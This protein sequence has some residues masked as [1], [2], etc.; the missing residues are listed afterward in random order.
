MKVWILRLRSFLDRLKISGV[1]YPKNLNRLFVSVIE[2]V[3]WKICNNPSFKK[4]Y[5]SEKNLSHFLGGMFTLHISLKKLWPHV[6]GKIVNLVGVKPNFWKEIWLPIYENNCWP[7]FFIEFFSKILNFF[8]MK[9]VTFFEKKLL[10]T[11]NENF[12]F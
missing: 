11:L 2:F 10:K 1:W 3:E 6:R 8:Q 9:N 12:I 7:S 5:L 4:V